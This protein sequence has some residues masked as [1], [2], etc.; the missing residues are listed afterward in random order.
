MTYCQAEET[1]LVAQRTCQSD[2]DLLDECEFTLG[3][4]EEKQSHVGHILASIGSSSS[5]SEA[6]TI[7]PAVVYTSSTHQPATGHCSIASLEVY[8]GREAVTEICLNGFSLREDEHSGTLVEVDND[9]LAYNFTEYSGELFRMNLTCGNQSS[10]LFFKLR[11]RTDLTS[12]KFDCS[13]HGNQSEDNLTQH[14]QST[15]N[16]AM[17]PAPLEATPR[18]ALPLSVLVPNTEGTKVVYIAIGVG[19]GGGLILLV[20]LVLGTAFLV[21]FLARR[22]VGS[23]GKSLENK[24]NACYITSPVMD[25]ASIA[26]TLRRQKEGESSPQKELQYTRAPIYDD[27]DF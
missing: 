16:C 23:R 17:C 2:Q 5:A 24:I 3:S 26:G 15:P 14:V 9:T 10:C 1:Y 7:V 8:R 25:T 19:G 22:R 21:V 13:G 12:G 4:N 18:N 20:A 6:V 11:G 27:L